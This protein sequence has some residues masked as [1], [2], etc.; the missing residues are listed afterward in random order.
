[1]DPAEEEEEKAQL[2]RAE[3]E[4]MYT[5]AIFVNDIKGQEDAMEDAIDVDSE[6]SRMMEPLILAV[7]NSSLNRLRDL[8]KSEP[9]NSLRSGKG[10]CAP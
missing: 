5:I 4:A 1:M 7:E 6:V 9:V 8:V 3:I 2:A 10:T